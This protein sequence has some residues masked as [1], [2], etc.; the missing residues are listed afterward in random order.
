M[1]G[2][3]TFAIVTIGALVIVMSA[4]SDVASAQQSGATGQGG[5]GHAQ[6]APR[7]HA[8]GHPHTP[9]GNKRIASPPPMVPFPNIGT[10]SGPLPIGVDLNNPPRDLFRGRTRGVNGG[11]FYPG[12]SYG[13]YPDA[14]MTSSATTPPAPANGM[15]R[16]QVTPGSAQVFVDGLY[17]GTVD[18]VENRR[19]LI[20][21][22][23]PHRLEIRGRGYEATTVDVRVIASDVV[24]YRTMLD[25]ERQPAAAPAAHGPTAIY[26]VPG[27]Y[28]GNV[29]PRKERVAPGCD[30]K[31]ARIVT[32][33]QPAQLSRP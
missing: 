17:S 11:G 28:M 5:G 25:L 6:N 19:G 10:L 18:D 4:R 29:P 13:A 3:R 14:G 23:G 8:Q 22:E 2:K 30:V 26:V 9:S 21:P 33:P 16:L 20:L 1:K 12:V 31:Q 7:S 15:L 24:T 32:P 27:C